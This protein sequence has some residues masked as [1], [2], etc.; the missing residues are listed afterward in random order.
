MARPIKDGL[1][2]FPLD[3]DFFKNRKVRG[4]KVRY[5]TKGIVLYIYILC[6]VYE[7]KGYYAEFDDELYDRITDD[8]GIAEDTARQILDYL[9]KRSMLD[10]KLLT[11]VK[12]LTSAP[13]Q[14]VFQ[15]A[16]KGSKR[17]IKVNKEYWLLS[18][19]ETL[20]FIK[21]GQNEGFSE[22]NG[23]FSEKN[24][25]YSEK[26]SINKRKENKRKVKEI[27]T[28]GVV[29][30]KK[31]VNAFEANIAPITSH[32]L[33]AMGSWLESVEEDVIIFAIT[34][35]VAH[36]VRKWSYIE[37]IL[38]NQFNAGNTTIESVKREKEQHKANPQ[39][40]SI[41]KDTTDYRYD[42]IERRMQEKYDR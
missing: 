13:I 14:K 27:I 2:Y 28:D 6:M 25:N 34:E 33:D 29:V 37:A 36:N 41:F 42:D 20:S 18:P 12:V 32:V 40:L 23:S 1:L 35:A 38:R 5:G 16:K 8:T 9:C 10:G 7:D 24:P 21:F 19:E 3:S 39:G 31:I 11:S 17:D 26:N 4:L 15:E 30:P 22:N